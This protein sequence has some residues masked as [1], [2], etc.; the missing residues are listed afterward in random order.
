MRNQVHFDIYL[1]SHSSLG[2]TIVSRYLPLR[3]ETTLINWSLSGVAVAPICICKTFGKL[4]WSLRTVDFTPYFRR[5]RC[6]GLGIGTIRAPI[7]KI[8]GISYNVLSD[9]HNSRLYTLGILKW[10]KDDITRK[11]IPEINLFTRKQNILAVRESLSAM[12]SRS[13][14]KHTHG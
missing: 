13:N 8:L 6:P 1:I 10:S 3:G 4:P 2:I 9:M 11:Y 12:F 14:N 7:V 5:H